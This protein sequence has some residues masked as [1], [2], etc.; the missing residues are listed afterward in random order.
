MSEASD[1]LFEA[2]LPQRLA[3]LS[4]PCMASLP[5]MVMPFIFSAV[6]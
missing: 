4:V 3:A 1:G 5:I 6:I 2:S